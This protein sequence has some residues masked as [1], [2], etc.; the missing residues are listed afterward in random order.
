MQ[1]GTLERPAP[2]EEYLEG[3]GRFRCAEQH[4]EVLEAM[5]AQVDRRWRTLLGRCGLQEPVAEL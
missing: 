3:Q 5:K 1:E 4:P 2:L